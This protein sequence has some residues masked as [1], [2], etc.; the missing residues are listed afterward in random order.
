[1]RYIWI[2][3]C[4]ATGLLIGVFVSGSTIVLGQPKQKPKQVWQ[5]K[6]IDAYKLQKYGGAKS[7][8]EGLNN[9]GVEGWELIAIDCGVPESRS[10]TDKEKDTTKPLYFVKPPTYY[11]KFKCQTE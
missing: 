11:L 8:E 3:A 9:L 6:V 10:A 1:M 4:L 7:P 2:C 5:Y